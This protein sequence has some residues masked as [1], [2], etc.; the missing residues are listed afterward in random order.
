A[1]KIDV[2]GKKM[3]LPKLEIPEF[4]AQFLKSNSFV[5][6]KKGG[7]A[8]PS[9]AQSQRNIWRNE[10]GKTAEKAAEDK[11]IKETHGIRKATGEEGNV[12]D[13]KATNANKLVFLQIGGS[14]NYVIGTPEQLKGEFTIPR[15][16]PEGKPRPLDVD[17]QLELQLGGSNTIDNMWLLDAS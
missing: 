16:G 5:T 2:P 6:I 14:G 1:G 15:W 12:V 13:D 10:V 8:R 17:H 3:L 11:L 9:G 4:K 7:E